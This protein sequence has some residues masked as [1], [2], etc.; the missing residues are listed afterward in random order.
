MHYL[1]RH[2]VQE[3]IVDLRFLAAVFVS[4]EFDA[5]GELGVFVVEF[6][7]GQLRQGRVRVRGGGP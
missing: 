6:D 1:N 2:V 5:F 3:S 7:R 4:V